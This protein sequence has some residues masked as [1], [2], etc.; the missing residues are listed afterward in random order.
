MAAV[1][2]DGESAASCG[3]D[4]RAPLLARDLVGGAAHDGDRGAH[5]LSH[6]AGSASDLG[7]ESGDC[8]RGG[9]QVVAGRLG[10]DPWRLVGD[11]ADESADVVT[12]PGEPG[13]G[14][15]RDQR[16]RAREPGAQR[17]QPGA[18]EGAEGVPGQVRVVDPRDI[19]PAAEVRGLRLDPHV[20]GQPAAASRARWV[21]D[22]ERSG[23]GEVRDEPAVGVPRHRQP[24]DEDEEGAP[25]VLRGGS[26][27]PRG[28]HPV[29]PRTTMHEPG[30]SAGGRPEPRKGHGAGGR[31][32]R[33][34]ASSTVM[35]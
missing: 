10:K 25:F 19:E 30:I 7:A 11:A 17:G 22:E 28:R 9:T 20:A 15:G 33:S 16:D 2:H 27:D 13:V 5:P 23:M 24:R 1:G 34:A 4:G 18:G 3:R 26:L 6:R 21:D 14:R 8:Q 12:Q 31:R 35:R 29:D 32:E